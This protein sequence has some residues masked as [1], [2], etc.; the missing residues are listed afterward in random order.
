MTFEKNPGFG[1][2]VLNPLLRPPYPVMQATGTQ[3]TM[4]SLVGEGG[5]WPTAW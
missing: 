4:G 5:T 2:T 1:N 3:V